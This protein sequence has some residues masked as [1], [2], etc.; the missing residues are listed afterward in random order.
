MTDVGRLLGCV[1]ELLR[2]P[3]PCGV[4]RVDRLVL[5]ALRP[6]KLLRPVLVVRS[7][8]AAARRPV[9]AEAE[10]RIVMGAFAVELLATLARPV[11]SAPVETDGA[12]RAA[13]LLADLP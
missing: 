7:A 4:P 5:D 10:R 3:A 11:T 8:A 9:D 1:R 2:T 6:G 13:R 12:A